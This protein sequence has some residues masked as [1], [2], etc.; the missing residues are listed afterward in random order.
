LAAAIGSLLADPPRRQALGSAGRAHVEARFSVER[1]VDRY[2]ALYDLE[3]AGAGR[4][5]RTLLP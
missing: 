1:M 2:L 3:G 5:A 4:D